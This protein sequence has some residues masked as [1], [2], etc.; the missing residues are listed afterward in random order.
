VI[1]IS[2]F[3]TISGLPYWEYLGEAN[4]WSAEVIYSATDDLPPYLSAIIR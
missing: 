1:N 3:E 2:G 4:E